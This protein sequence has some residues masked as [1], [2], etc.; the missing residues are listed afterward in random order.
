MISGL[1]LSLLFPLA[2]FPDSSACTVRPITF[3]L[4]GDIMLGTD[5]PDSLR[6]IPAADGRP[7]FRYAGKILST[8][9]VAVGN[10]E[11]PITGADSSGKA[12]KDSTVYVFRMPPN[13]AA[14]LAEAGFDVLTTAN[15]H[16]N[17]F[18]PAGRMETESILDS[19]GIRHTGRA[20]DVASLLVRGTS[21]AVIGFSTG[22]GHH[23]LL[24]VDGAVE[25]VRGLKSRHDIVAVSFHGG[26]EGEEYMNLPDGPE[27]YLGEPRGD[28]REFAHRVVDAGADI[29]FGHGPHV[30]RGIEV[31][32]GRIIAYSLGNFC[33][34]FGVN[35]RGMNGLAPL[36]WVEVAPDGA[37]VSMKILSFEQETRHYPVPDPRRR[38]EKVIRDL[39]V[40]DFGSFPAEFI[41]A[42]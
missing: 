17:D 24:D 20:G 28:L 42:E 22:P 23:S 4:V 31:Y 2:A 26:G 40:E 13:L 29:V 1:L 18:G 6:N 10:L 21:V 3:A 15:N 14:S 36:L 12:L 39:S 33:T 34:W 5:Y 38:V 41:R 27:C 19:L 35:V 25:T 7:L 9:D 37:L 32:R 16:S 11:G 30:P 8:A